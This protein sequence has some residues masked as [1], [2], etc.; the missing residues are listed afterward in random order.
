MTTPPPNKAGDKRAMSRNFS[1]D[2]PDN[3]I[4]VGD[5]ALINMFLN[6]KAAAFTLAERAMATNPMEKD[7]IAGPDSIEILARVTARLG[8]PDRAISALQQLLSIPYAGPFGVPLTPALLRLDPMFDSLR[9]DARF[10]KLV[11]SPS[12]D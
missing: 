7:A 8:E 11:A 1:K 5:L 2:Q 6:N 10:Q 3:D 4:L 9:N 12:S